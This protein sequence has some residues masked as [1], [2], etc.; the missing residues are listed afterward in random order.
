MKPGDDALLSESDLITQAIETFGNIEGF[1]RIADGRDDLLAAC[2]AFYANGFADEFGGDADT[3]GHYYRV[4]RW[5]VWTDSQGFHK[6]ET[7]DNESDARFAFANYDSEYVATLD[8][9]GT[10]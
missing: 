6:V 7:Y 4:N 10:M 1:I 5:I 9:H 3:Y 8:K 2:E